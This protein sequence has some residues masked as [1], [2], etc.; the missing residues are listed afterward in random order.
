M[1]EPK[2]IS[3][4]RLENTR[5]LASKEGTAGFARRMGMSISQAGQLIGRSPV[6]N[7]GNAIARRIDDAY[8]K[9]KG[10]LDIVHDEPPVGGKRTV[11]L[12]TATDMETLA[13]RV[14][15]FKA[16]G[17]M[18]TGLAQPEVD[19][20]VG[21][22]PLDKRFIRQ[23]FPSFSSFEN[24]AVITGLGDSMEP[25]FRDGDVLVVDRGVT[26]VKVDT[27]Y[28]MALRNELYIKRLTRNPVSKNLEMS[29][30]ARPNAS[31]EIPPS[32]MID[33]QVLGRVIW[34][35]NGKRISS[36]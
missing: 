32:A 2:P 18:G 7:I 34:V 16:P 6:R 24:L 33:F 10:W 31:I 27:I 13:V 11:A 17:S 35:W 1:S 19:T 36:G 8:D 14:P 4:T 26:E 29:S 5:A 12:A 28:V 3:Q 25:T 30:D 22:L 23:N 21:D 9:P 15:R 20:I